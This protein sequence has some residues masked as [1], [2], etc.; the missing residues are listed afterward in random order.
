MGGASYENEQLASPGSF[1]DVANFE[2]V[3]AIANYLLYL[4]ANNTA[5]NEYF[6]WKKEYK[7]L[8]KVWDSRPCRLCHALNNSS[9]P[10]KVY[11]NM[12]DFWGRA[13]NCGKR[14][15][16]SKAYC[17]LRLIMVLQQITKIAFTVARRG[18]MSKK[19]LAF[20]HRISDK[21]ILI[22]MVMLVLLITLQYMGLLRKNMMPT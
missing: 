12:D 1:M 3:E 22:V 21:C 18:R 16:N 17:R 6:W 4:N 20:L 13:K 15:E 8:S 5:Y 7:V 9:L 19:S 10:S 2:S 14:R 11:N